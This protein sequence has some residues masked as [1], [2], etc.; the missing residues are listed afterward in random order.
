MLTE[1]AIEVAGARGI[2]T[3]IRFRGGPPVTLRRIHYGVVFAG[4]VGRG[5]VG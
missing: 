3:A 4:T 5:G 2:V 1:T